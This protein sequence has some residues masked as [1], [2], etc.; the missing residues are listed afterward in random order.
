MKTLQ[1]CNWKAFRVEDIFEISGTITTHPSKLI[2][3]GL[4]PRITCA[5]T[6]NG[7]D[8][9]YQNRP[10]ESGNVLT[11]D[12]ATIGFV[13]YQ[14][15]DFL[16]TDHVEKLTFKGNTFN[17]YIALFIK[18]CIDNSK[19]N[20]FGY[21]YKF[22]QR[23]I[24]RQTFMLPCTDDDTPDYEFMESYM[25]EKE[26]FLLQKYKSYISLK[27][28]D[29][30]GGITL[31]NKQ[32]KAFELTDIF[33]IKATSS[34]IDRNKLTGESGDYP[35]ITRT[36]SFNGW[37]SFIA[38]QPNY[39]KDRG[40]V[41]SIGLDT[42][43]AFYQ[44]IE[45][46]TGQ[47]IQ[48]FSNPQMTKYIAAFML[49]LLKIQLAKFNW[50]GNGATLGRLK[51]LHIMLPT[52]ENSQPDFMFMHNYMLNKELLLLHQYAIVKLQSLA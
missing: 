32:W 39:K 18:M 37:D 2:E 35:Y 15:A 4:T 20:K 19:E 38:Q 8:G 21:G 23:R 51:R 52:N 50:G 7:L 42:Q 33:T 31:N 13:S 48:V 28:N 46:Y 22:A 6:N 44:P 10:T 24:K 36:D 49:P 26:R 11:V 27:I 29:L 1:Q 17:R 3:Q 16:A 43:T 45:F 12:S 5:A 25:R 34:G 14:E 40:N 30:W 41:I 47:N 9:F